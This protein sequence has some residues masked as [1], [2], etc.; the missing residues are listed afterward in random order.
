[1]V[2]TPPADTRGPIRS[3]ASNQPDLQRDRGQLTHWFTT[4]KRQAAQTAAVGISDQPKDGL[5][6]RTKAKRCKLC[7]RLIALLISSWAW[8]RSARN[9]LRVHDVEPELHPRRPCRRPMKERLANIA[10]ALASLNTDVNPV[11]GV[12]DRQTC[13]RLAAFV[14]SPPAT[15]SPPARSSRTW[16]GHNLPQ[17]AHPHA[18]NRLG[19]LVDRTVAARRADLRRRRTG[20]SRRFAT[21]RASSS[22]IP[23]S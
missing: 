9:R 17:S 23:C 19:R 15:R 3:A 14:E 11:A 10:S 6:V 2:A 5:A 1:M 12:P 18:Q 4:S 22:F 16:A 21:T 7:G 20:R 13:E 8:V